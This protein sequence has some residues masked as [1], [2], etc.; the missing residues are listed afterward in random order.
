M[1]WCEVNRDAF[2]GKWALYRNTTQEFVCELQ[3]LADGTILG[4]SK[5]ESY[6]NISGD[7][8][9]VLNDKSEITTRFDTI[10]GLYDSAPE[11][12]EGIFVPSKDSD[13][14]IKHI[15]LRFHDIHSVHSGRLYH[16]AQTAD[17]C[18]EFEANKVD[19]SIILSERK[20]ITLPR[21]VVLVNKS[22]RKDFF[23]S[24]TGE[25]MADEV[26]CDVIH[27]ATVIGGSVVLDR[28]NIPLFSTVYHARRPYHY[29]GSWLEN[30]RVFHC[31][32][33]TGEYVHGSTFFFNSLSDP[34]FAH[35]LVQE[36]PN[37]VVLERLQALGLLSEPVLHMAPLNDVPFRK[38]HFSDL[39]IDFPI[40]IPGSLHST[41]H[42]E[43]LYVPSLHHL[44]R[45]Y[46]FPEIVGE[47]F[48][49]LHSATG[50]PQ[51]E[52]RRLF[53][54]RKSVNLRRGYLN[55]DEVFRA[56]ADIGFE[57]VDPMDLP[58]VEKRD[59]FGRAEIIMDVHGGGLHNVIY[60]P[61]ECHVIEIF[62]ENHNNWWNYHIS[63]LM[64]RR[65]SAICLPL[66]PS[67]RALPVE[68]ICQTVDIPLFVS[69]V[70]EVLRGLGKTYS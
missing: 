15:L 59:I 51:P 22:D 65:Y 13:N 4:S 3:F 40:T 54:S 25:Y 43:R 5:N 70:Q 39:G 37:S 56:L 34:Q 49:R 10:K 6:W 16:V 26:R 62:N 67:Q 12:L 8:L 9:E 64:G 14:P 61:E 27:D 1:G 50:N 66:E 41:K 35:W 38:Q 29:N 55:E 30:E 36:L 47:S 69:C 32:V 28:N 18:R 63:S 45:V 44:P 11:K 23:A 33:D 19:Y 46:A 31:A 52:N 58:E 24:F 2:H 68:Q 60:T 48:R 7:A 57:R 17:M 53:L 42:Y 20:K 21:P